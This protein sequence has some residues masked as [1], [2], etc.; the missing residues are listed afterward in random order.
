MS[1]FF[2]VGPATNTNDDM[3]MSPPQKAAGAVASP[4]I[5]PP[6]G[7]PSGQAATTP[8]TTPL[9]TPVDKPADTL[10]VPPSTTSVPTP[11][12]AFEHSKP[13][14][15]DSA[16][17]QA[18]NSVSEGDLTFGQ[19]P[20]H[21]SVDDIFSDT[22][23]PTIKDDDDSLPLDPETN[24]NDIKESDKSD[25]TP[26]IKETDLNLGSSSSD[27]ISDIE[28]KLKDKKSKLDEDIKKA[29]T[30]LDK[31]DE[32]MKKVAELKEQESKV[33]STLKELI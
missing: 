15:G 4:T 19:K 18:E 17:S 1:G 14:G 27:S 9:A 31:I 25:E 26:T 28:A 24:S 21:D 22:P 30:E 3:T 20:S 5:P 8:A 29:Q 10:V 7:T 32:A 11:T 6:T 33:L 23:A 13:W 2:G 12:P 16:A